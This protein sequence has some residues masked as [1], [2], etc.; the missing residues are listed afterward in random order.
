MKYSSTDL[1]IDQILPSFGFGDAIGTDTLSIRN[2]IRE[3]GLRS[4]IFVEEGIVKKYSR[5]FSDYSQNNRKNN[6]L[7]HH[8]SIGSLI[9]N[10]LL[11]VRSK[12]ITRYHNITPASFFNFKS[13]QEIRWRTSQ[14]RSQ[15]PLV[16]KISDSYLSVSGYNEKELNPSKKKDYKILPLMRNYENLLTVPD[17]KLTLDL[18]KKD[19]RKTIL[20]VGRVIPNKAHHDLL[21]FVKLY[22]KYFSSNLKLVCVGN[23]NDFYL[24]QVLKQVAKELNLK[25]CKSKYVKSNNDVIF[26]GPID[27][28]ALTTYYR[29]SDTF[30]CLS[31][32][33]GF[34]V[35]L[36]EAM[37][38][39]LPILAHA[40]AAVPETLGFG[41]MLI[42]KK[43]P[44][45]FLEALYSLL[46]DKEVAD[47]YS[48]LSQKRST[49]FS[50]NVLKKDFN[51]YL[52]S[53]I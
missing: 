48:R 47:K 34:C 25:I 30:V 3:K 5:H 6:I 40:A 43:S 33:E 7:L 8:F 12:T 24:N 46:N 21:L 2:I 26:T 13:M 45:T 51:E 27:L 11:N 19:K 41:G 23:Y 50:W 37:H 42:N 35:P 36:V 53:L 18:L 1:R 4:E 38:F 52:D 39:N 22:K 14:G 28:S 9:P 10:Y 49:D 44:D 32:H 16:K 15:I 31:D 20:F 29:Y 17:C